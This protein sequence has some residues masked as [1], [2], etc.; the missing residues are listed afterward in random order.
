M[1]AGGD[2]SLLY[3]LHMHVG[4]MRVPITVTLAGRINHKQNHRN[5]LHMCESLRL[6]PGVPCIRPGGRHLSRKVSAQQGAQG[7]AL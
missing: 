3:P 5:R 2:A 6:V 7:R 1:D 4:L